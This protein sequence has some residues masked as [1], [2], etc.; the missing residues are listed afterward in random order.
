MKE[1]WWCFLLFFCG[2]G[3][4]TWCSLG[5]CCFSF[6]PPF[7]WCCAPPPHWRGVAVSFFFL[8][9]HANNWDTVIG[10]CCFLSFFEWC[11]VPFPFL[12]CCVVFLRLIGVVLRFPLFPIVFW[13]IQWCNNIFTNSQNE[14]KVRQ[15]KSKLVV[16]LLFRGWC[17][18]SSPFSFFLVALFAFH[19]RWLCCLPLPPSGGAVFVVLWVV[20][21][22][23]SSLVGSAVPFSSH[24]L[25]G[26]ASLPPPLEKLAFSPLPST[27][28]W[29]GL[30]QPLVVWLGWPFLFLLNEM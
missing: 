21:L 10:G 2:V 5:W 24:L 30:H 14:S 8:T 29:C 13:K 23:P 20:L 12:F 25:G 3:V 4:V 15:V 11:C 27:C 28:G 22:S 7:A 9:W 1:K 18:F 16:A 19:F 17:S 6:P 26:A